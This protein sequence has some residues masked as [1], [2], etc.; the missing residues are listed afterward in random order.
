MR[1]L[2]C[3][4]STAGP[5]RLWSVLPGVL[6]GVLVVGP[7]AAQ[8]GLGRGTAPEI[9]LQ[10]QR[11]FRGSDLRGK[12]GPLAKMGF[13]LAL[14]Y[15]EHEAFLRREA[16]GPFIAAQ[17]PLAQV[18]DDHVLV[19]VTASGD[20][21]A[22]QSALEALGLTNGTHYGPVVSGWLPITA[23]PSAA[24]LNNLRFARLSAAMTSVGLTTSQGDKAQMSD[25]ARI[26]FLIDGS[27]VTVGSLS[28]SFDCLLGAAGDVGTGDLPAGI[29][30][31][32]DTICPESDEGRGMMQLIHD[33]APGASQSFHTAFDGQA[34][35]ALGIEELAGCP[36]GSGMGCTPAADPAEV[37]VDDVFYFAEPFFQDGIIAQ[38][39]DAVVAA[40]T[41]YFSSAGNSARQAYESPFVSSGLSPPGAGGGMAHD[42]D[43][44]AGTDIFQE[45]I[46]PSGTTFISLQWDQP[47]ASA[48]GST[49]DIDFHLYLEPPGVSPVITS[50]DANIGADPI[51]ILGIAN[52]G[53]P[54]PV[55]L[56]I[57]NVSGADPGVMKYVFFNAG[58]S[59]ID[60]PTDS[61]TVIGHSNAEGAQA[62]GAAFY[63]ETPPFG[64]APPLL[65]SFSS[66]G[67]QPILF[68]LADM[69]IP[70]PM[71]QKPEIV[72][73]DGTNTTFFGSDI[74]D[75]GDG[76]DVDVFPNFFGTSA[77]APHAAAVAALLLGQAALTPS[78]LYQVLQA[79]GID[80]LAPGVDFDSGSGLIDALNAAESTAAVSAAC[81][82]ADLTLTG[83][84]NTGS[85]TFRACDSL[86]VG[87]G[88]FSDVT[89]IAD[90]I[91][92][93]DGFESGDTSAWGPP[94]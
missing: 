75:P 72:A 91:I 46:L 18:S 53:A 39:V 2:L 57:E 59:V 10:A 36:P 17:M 70:D 74:P 68:D 21:A 6:A 28:D 37:I 51:E 26:A 3:S 94:P 56:V 27:G 73:P 84:P 67:P 58:M 25:L 86:T 87:M 33:V 66:A 40:G 38:A 9:L 49:N 24:A 52:G 15:R 77:A 41:A 16:P 63:F 81:G 93:A 47:Y 92:F 34:D 29:E 19:D 13:D 42:F 76:S 54:L 71:R 30:V 79:S 5:R 7:A 12:D 8:V 20:A 55:N 35:F 48:G 61:G 1:R 69:P 11:D 31:L 60:F 43:P 64:I 45:I 82:V 78:G 23:I 4:D 90:S 62:V 32:D 80:M 50:D 88:D 89:G 14:L 22:L 83:K 44:G 85:Q 65:E